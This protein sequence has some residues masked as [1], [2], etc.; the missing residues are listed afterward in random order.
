MQVLKSAFKV[1][2]MMKEEKDRR[3]RKP[4]YRKRE[5]KRNEKRREKIRKSK[6]WYKKGGKESVLFVTATPES[7]LKNKLQKEIEKSTL[8]SKS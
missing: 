5:W 3:G 1:F 7:E 2:E 4:M 8:R 6:D